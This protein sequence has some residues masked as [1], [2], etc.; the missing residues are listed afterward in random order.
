MHLYI[1]SK[2]PQVVKVFVAI[3]RDSDL[4]QPVQASYVIKLP[5]QQHTYL[6]YS[7]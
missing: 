4:S 5:K 1:V 7:F 3:K 6:Y 2:Y